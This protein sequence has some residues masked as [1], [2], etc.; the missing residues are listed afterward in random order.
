MTQVPLVTCLYC[1]T[2]IFEQFINLCI[3]LRSS[4]KELIIDEDYH[5]LQCFGMCQLTSAGIFLSVLSIWHDIIQSTHHSNWHDSKW[6][7]TSYRYQY[8]EWVDWCIFSSHTLDSG[9]QLKFHWLI[10]FRSLSNFQRVSYYS[11]G[12]PLRYFQLFVYHGGFLGAEE[13]KR[14]SQK[15]I[16]QI[17]ICDASWL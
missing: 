16:Y 13:E 17:L 11:S 2:S 1:V 9:K 15:K 6:M 4:K 7:T 10:S 14:W 3:C 8:H 12:D 5:G